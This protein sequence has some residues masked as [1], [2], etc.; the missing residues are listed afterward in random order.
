MAIQPTRT[1]THFYSTFATPFGEFSVTVDETGAVTA[2][3][4][5]DAARLRSYLDE[6][7]LAADETRTAPAREQVLAY[8]AGRRH[9]FDLPLAPAG[10][11]FQQRVWAALR[12]IPFGKTCSYGEVA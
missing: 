7:S 8:C 5:G 4:F 2:T 12:R 9:D 10:T 3:A 11:P 1:M 6:P